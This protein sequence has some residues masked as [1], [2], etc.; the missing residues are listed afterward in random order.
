MAFY[1][2]FVYHLIFVSKFFIFYVHYFCI[3]FLLLFSL[4]AV[5]RLIYFLVDSRAPENSLDVE[6][7]YKDK[8][9]E[10]LNN[11]MTSF[12]IIYNEKIKSHSASKSGKEVS[13]YGPKRI[14]NPSK[15]N[16]SPYVNQKS[17]RYPVTSRMIQLHD[18]IVTLSLDENYK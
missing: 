13:R 4:F 7:L 11:L 14:L 3:Y 5:V 10:R 16:A 9:D 12:E 15:Y 17:S 6:I 2:H 18:A 1:S 8:K